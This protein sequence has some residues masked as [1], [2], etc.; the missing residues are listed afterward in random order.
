MWDQCGI[1]AR[2]QCGISVGSAWDQCGGISVGSVWDHMVSV[3]SMWDQ[4]GITVAS[5]WGDHCG[6]KNYCGIIVEE[7]VA[8]NS[9]SV[10]LMRR[11]LLL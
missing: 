7:S 8:G 6:I 4:C 3:G 11:S 9:T 1:S 2:Y 10:G 5:L